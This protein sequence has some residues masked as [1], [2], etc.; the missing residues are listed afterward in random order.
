MTDEELEALK[1]DPDALVN[2]LKETTSTLQKVTQEKEDTA[3][4]LQESEA[5]RQE[6]TTNFKKFRDMSAEEKELLSE[7]E[8]ELMQRQEKLEEEREKDRREREEWQAGQIK[9]IENRYVKQLSG[10][11]EKI[12]EKILFHYNRLSDK[13]DDEETIE[14]KMNDAYRLLGDERPDPLRRAISGRGASPEVRSK[15]TDFS[16]TEEGKGLGSALG[17]TL[18]A[19]K[20]NK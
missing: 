3:K 5:R 9:K 2:K 16:E 8:K 14:R 1:S 20:S 11:D 12:A 15:S 17:L 6:Q 19:P 10:G 13:A 4:K 18:E 7:K